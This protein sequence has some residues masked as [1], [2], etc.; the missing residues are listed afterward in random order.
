MKGR[1]TPVLHGAPKRT[2]L[3]FTQTSG[4]GRGTFVL[5]GAPTRIGGRCCNMRLACAVAASFAAHKAPVTLAPTGSTA[6]IKVAAGCCSG[7]VLGADQATAV[8]PCEFETENSDAC[9]V[10]YCCGCDKQTE[11]HH[12]Q[13]CLHAGVGCRC[14]PFCYCAA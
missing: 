4:W 2:T 6:A 10:C 1:S 9:E 3:Q 5:H 11:I 13:P 12:N 14:M 8:C 7:C